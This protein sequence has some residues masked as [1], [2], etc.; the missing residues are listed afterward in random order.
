MP[1]YDSNGLS[2]LFCRTH[3]TD[4]IKLKKLLSKKAKV[5]RGRRILLNIQITSFAWGIEFVGFLVTC[6]GIMVFGEENHVAVFCIQNFTALVYFIIIPGS[7][8]INTRQIKTSILEN[9]FYLTFVDKCFLNC[10][11]RINSTVN[12]D[13]DENQNVNKENGDG[14]KYASERNVSSNSDG[15][16]HNANDGNDDV[17]KNEMNQNFRNE[18]SNL[19]KKESDEGSISN[20]I[21][22]R[23]RK[24]S[25][26]VE[27]IE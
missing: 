19:H 4:M 22:E 18:R 14:P 3:K 27:D 12:H 11:N 13:D 17:S 25:L 6:L 10:V 1:F 24:Q 7:Y 8:L 16:N 9:S 23:Q 2:S 20:E 5:K 26:K 21:K 15:N